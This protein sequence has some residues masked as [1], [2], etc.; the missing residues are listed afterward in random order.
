M[1][2]RER[3]RERE[4]QWY[5]CYIYIYVYHCLRVK[6]YSFWRVGMIMSKLKNKFILLNKKMH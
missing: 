2:E 4:Q 1:E 6:L 3:E 5:I